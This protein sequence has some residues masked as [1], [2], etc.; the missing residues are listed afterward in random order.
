MCGNRA[1]KGSLQSFAI[2]QVAQLRSNRGESRE[3]TERA[4]NRSTIN[5]LGWSCLSLGLATLIICL[6]ILPKPGPIVEIN[7]KTGIEKKTFQF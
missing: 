3:R 1:P 4:M 7:G 2:V 5:L 6:F